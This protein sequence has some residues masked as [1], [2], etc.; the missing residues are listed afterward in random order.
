MAAKPAPYGLRSASLMELKRDT[1]PFRAPPEP[2]NP[3]LEPETGLAIFMDLFFSTETG[4]AYNF[5]LIS[6]Y[7]LSF[8]WRVAELFKGYE[9]AYFFKISLSPAPVF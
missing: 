1:P 6:L 5:E 9:I 3:G 7:L 2:N 8:D 4:A